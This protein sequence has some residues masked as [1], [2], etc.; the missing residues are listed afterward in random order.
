LNAISSLGRCFLLGVP[1]RIAGVSANDGRPL[2]YVAHERLRQLG[3]RPGERI[4]VGGFSNGR[5]V[6]IGRVIVHVVADANPAT[7]ILEEPVTAYCAIGGPPFSSSQS[8]RVVPETIARSIRTAS[9][10]G[11]RFSRSTAYEL[12]PAALLGIAQLDRESA[13]ALERLLDDVPLETPLGYSAVSAVPPG[14]PV[15]AA[16]RFEQGSDSHAPVASARDIAILEA[17]AG[18]QTLGEIAVRFGLSRQRIGQI[19]NRAD[20]LG[21]SSNT[22]GDRSDSRDAG[23][24]VR[25]LLQAAVLGSGLSSVGSSRRRALGKGP[26]EGRLLGFVSQRGPTEP[27]H[28]PEPAWRMEARAAP[29]NDGGTARRRR[30]M[31][32]SP[33]G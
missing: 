18:G 20:D 30:L 26:N 2:R 3:L 23:V 11:L 12:H 32:L 9:G 28:N 10:G 29:G 14:P 19:I 1:G 31:P 21:P 8:G 6:L 22:F 7:A 15:D 25:P 4:Y 16:T 33:Q 5:L 27:R 13:V 24:R 17:R